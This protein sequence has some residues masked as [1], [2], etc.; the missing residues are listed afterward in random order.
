MMALARKLWPLPRSIS[1]PG[2]VQTLSLIKQELPNLE[3]QEICS[4]EKVFDWTVPDE[5]EAIG[6]YIETPDGTRICDFSENN[7]H[8]VGYS[9][10][11]N[12]Y[13][14]LEELQSHLHSLPA[15]PDAIPYVTSYYQDQWG[16]AL[17][18]KQRE[19]LL[20]GL[21]KVVVQ[22]KKFAGK[23][24]FGEL[25][26]PGKTDKEIFFSTY[27][28]HPSMANN[29]LSGPVLAT[30][31]AKELGKMDNYYTYRF[32]FIPETI[33]SL[34]YMSR[35]LSEMKKNILAGFIL[36]CV[37][38]ER[39]FSYVPSRSGNS[40]ADKVALGVASKLDLNLKH[41]SWLDRGSDE[42]QYCSP[43]ADLPVCSIMRSKY[44]EYPEYH[45]SL[46][47]LDTVV[48]ARGLE[49][50]LEFYLA[51][52]SDI[53]AKRFPRARYVGEPQLGKRHLYPNTSIKGSFGTAR[54]LTDILSL[55]DGSLSV[56][57]ICQILDLELAQLNDLLAVLAEHQLVDA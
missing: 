24:T 3:F 44:G 8:L 47:Q 57:E 19:S 48:T 38:D 22:T 9:I 46:D 4:G 15:Q 5:W 20:P 45:T 42:R 6:A 12:S 56:E 17:T 13:M 14:Q 50:S 34:I 51:M 31:I 18:H 26:M 36:T 30:Q 41:Y 21:Y 27:V 25:V 49:E 52:I 23:L 7:L 43:G 37:G 53:E 32:V 1:G 16:F 10:P 33:G 28:C 39:E 29:E 35:N 40:V 54:K 11:V 2:L 55:A